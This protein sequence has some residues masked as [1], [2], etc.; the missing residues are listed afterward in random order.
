MNE[1]DYFQKNCL[2]KLEDFVFKPSIS[3]LGQNYT[4]YEHVNNSV[5][6]PLAMNQTN[7]VTLR[8]NLFNLIFN[9]KN[10]NIL[11]G[12]NLNTNY[13]DFSESVVKNFNSIKTQ[14]S[15]DQFN[16]ENIVKI[17][18]RILKNFHIY[19][20]SLRLS[21]LTDKASS[22]TKRIMSTLVDNYASKE[23]SLY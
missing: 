9:K 16:N 17:M 19:W 2:A 22:D 21:N 4:L 12:R 15:K 13:D 20:N 10:L 5:Y 18:V 11:E 6:L 7:Y 23:N 14:M 3:T 8:E 1:S